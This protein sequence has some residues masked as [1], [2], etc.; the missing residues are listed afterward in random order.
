MFFALNLENGSHI[1]NGNNKIKKKTTLHNFN[2]LFNSKKKKTR[3]NISVRF[4]FNIIK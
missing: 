3:Y 4:Y 1:N 2:T